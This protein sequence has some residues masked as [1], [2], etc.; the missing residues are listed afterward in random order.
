VTLTPDEVYHV[1][2]YTQSNGGEK[3]TTTEIEVKLIDGTRLIGI[4][5]SDTE[6]S[7]ERKGHTSLGA[8][9]LRVDE[10]TSADGWNEHPIWFALTH[11]LT[12]RP[13]L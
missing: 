7:G 9:W 10:K 6:R 12:V 11:V 3:D 4:W 13:V 1:D 2:Q 5:C 8:M